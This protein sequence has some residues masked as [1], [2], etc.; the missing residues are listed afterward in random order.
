MCPRVARSCHTQSHAVSSQDSL[1]K[2]S[3]RARWA[4]PRYL[5]WLPLDHAGD[6]CPENMPNCTAA[7]TPPPCHPA[8]S[9]MVISLANQ[10]SFKQVHHLS[11]HPTGECLPVTCLCKYPRSALVI[12][13]S[14]S[15][16]REEHNTFV[17]GIGEKFYSYLKSRHSI[18]PIT[19]TILPCSSYIDS[20]GRT[21]GMLAGRGGP[22][23]SSL[24]TPRDN[25]SSP[26]AGSISHGDL[27]AP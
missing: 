14:L 22:D 3:S 15:L 6:T 5:V 19:S 1:P 8:L 21:N 10:E 11:R 20:K 23:F 16:K 24:T 18:R 4:G 17:R 2:A 7:L 25:V 9:L 13:L 12:P 27:S 26:T